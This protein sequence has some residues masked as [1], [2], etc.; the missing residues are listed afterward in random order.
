MKMPSM[1]KDTLALIYTPGVG[2]ISMR[3]HQDPPSVDLF[4]NRMNMVAVI[5]Q[6]KT[7]GLSPLATLPYL[8]YLSVQLKSIAGLDAFPIVVSH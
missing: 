4:T 2:E 3:I 5:A 1:S 6:G 7:L 8:D